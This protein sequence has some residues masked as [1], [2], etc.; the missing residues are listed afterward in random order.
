MQLYLWV[1]NGANKVEK[2]E[3][4]V[5]AVNYLRTDPT[6]SRD[7]NTPLITVKQGFE[8]PTFTGWFGAW[9]PSK[10]NVRFVFILGQSSK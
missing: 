8:P 9:D 10:W 4:L 7:P 5:T 3:A 6:G 2:K 1:G